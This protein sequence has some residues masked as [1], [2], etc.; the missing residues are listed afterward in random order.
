MNLFFFFGRGV[1]GG[2]GLGNHLFYSSSAALRNVM[3]NS[4]GRKCLGTSEI[5]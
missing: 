3:K 2:G 5:F 4:V 1:G